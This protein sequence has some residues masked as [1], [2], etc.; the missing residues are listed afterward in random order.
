MSPDTG[1]F[2]RPAI[3]AIMDFQIADNA[4]FEM[5]LTHPSFDGAPNYQ[6]LEFLGDRVLGLVIA[7]WLVESF[8]DEREGELSRRLIALVRKEKLAEIG[9]QLNL[10]QYVRTSS[11]G[12]GAKESDN[13]AIVADVVEALIGALY[14]AGGLEAAAKFIKAN[15]QQ[16]LQQGTAARDAKTTLQELAQG[17][18]LPLP[19]YTVLNRS[20]PDHRPVFKISVNVEGLGQAAASGA[21][22]RE[23]EIKAAA[24]LLDQLGKG[25]AR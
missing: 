17:Q 6:R 14:T 20:G 7:S 12:K 3:E 2:D 18:G 23:A 22:K 21:S 5:A 16:T 25:V 24:N 10:Q 1:D 13:P 19:E 11:M 9:L 15:W 8:P 4:L